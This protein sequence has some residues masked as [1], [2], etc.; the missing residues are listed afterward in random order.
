MSKSRVGNS[1]G[2]IK[3]HRSMLD[4]EWYQDDRCVR[5][6]LHLHLKANYLPGRWKGKDVEPGQVVTSTVA[7]A[8]QLGWSRSALVRTLD[9]LKLAREVDTKAD[10]KW[11]LVT[12]IKWDKFQNDD[13]QPDSKSD[14][15]RT[16]SGQQTGQQ[17]D[18][19]EEGE[20]RKKEKNTPDG[21]VRDAPE[22]FEAF[23]VKYPIKK[24][25]GAAERAWL[26]VPKDQRPL[27]AAAI[28]AQLK[29][30]HFRGTD[31]KDYIPYPAT[32]LNEQ[33]WRDEVGASTST[34]APQAP[35]TKEEAWQKIM[36]IKAQRG[37][38]FQTHDVPKHIVEAY[39]RSA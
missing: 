14:S 28:E 11:T 15:K 27:C 16:A 33:R 34:A 5:L 30:H 21:V 17:A 9:R 26:K 29:A 12:L 24:A 18:T 31:G 22:G 23:Y 32:W 37:A 38:D 39:R 6:L 35:L 2:F 7:L 8:E 19:I 13:A 3:I 4:W 1:G 36:E 20:E 25:R 10:S